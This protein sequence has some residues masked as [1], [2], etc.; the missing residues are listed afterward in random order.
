V[1]S[2]DCSFHFDDAQNIVQN[3]LIRDITDV[4]AWWSYVPSRPL[5]IFT[6][7]LNYHFNGLDVW[8]YHL[9][10]LL[11]H[12]CNAV[13]VF[14]LVTLIFA[15]PGM[16]NSPLLKNAKIIALITALLFVAHPVQTQAVTYIVQR[17][18]SLAALFYLLSLCFFI[19]GRTRKL[20]KNKQLLFF[21]LS[22]ISALLAFLTKEN[23]YTLPLA[24]LLFEFIFIRESRIR[25]NFKDWKIWTFSG[26]IIL[27]MIFIFTNFSF[28]IFNPILP[29]QGNTYTVTAGT[30]LLTQ[31]RVVL[32]YMRLLV[33]PAWQNLDYDY[34]LSESIFEWK[35]FTSF[36]VLIAIL[37]L[38]VLFIKK[39]RLAAY[40]MIFFFTALLIECSI[41]PIPNVIFEH[42]MYLPSV[43]FFI[44][45]SSI[46][47][48]FVKGK[49]AQAVIVIMFLLIPLLS[50][51]TVS[52]NN[53]WKT[54][55]SLWSDVMKKS[56][57]K[58]R[59]LNNYGNAIMAEG[60]HAESIIY[61][62]R[63]IACNPSFDMSYSNRGAAKHMIH[64]YA[65]SVGDYGSA[66][67][68]NPKNE[69]AYCNRAL[70]RKALLD[71][72]GAIAD[73]DTAIHLAPTYA[74]AWSQRALAK[75]AMGDTAAAIA[76]LEHAL[77]LHPE[78]PDPY[79]E[80]G[81]IM[82]DKHN[83]KKAIEY[84]SEA[85]KLFPDKADAWFNRGF[86]YAMMNDMQ[87]AIRDLDVA[88]RL[89]PKFAKGYMNRAN[90]KASIKDYTGAIDD[91]SKVLELEPANS[92]A[93]FSRGMVHFLA[94]D[95]QRAC[96]DW[97]QASQMG[98]PQAAS[99]LISNCRN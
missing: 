85:A 81:T 17:L 78:I 19:Y 46:P 72:K 53:V 12:L 18:A 93:L 47:F 2:F 69:M 75:K 39:Y 36:V 41:I 7:A 35:T 9:V 73:I 30:Y 8:G 6:F 87:A 27:L 58:T 56:P 4:S 68:C 44:F 51:L 90:A 66:I 91:F 20:S 84:Y 94:N 67:R 88:L 48:Y 71:F 43:G 55:L 59:P 54:D 14:W 34:P 42:R 77:T 63:A 13:L 62:T 21:A 82:S 52:R 23:T 98:N 92:T 32:T 70:A 83:F 11:I 95:R 24:I 5:G 65:G 80:L 28:T 33:F 96:S 64:N 37:A 45:I 50:F 31:F 97:Q 57:H 1:N 38:C 25:I 3:K 86:A 10:N 79:N 99:A 16:K 29:E 74:S 89:D 76:D 40:G 26:I 22:G 49:N 60:K 61:F 15:T